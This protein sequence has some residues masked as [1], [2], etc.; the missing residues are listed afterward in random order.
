LGTAAVFFPTDLAPNSF[1]EWS[2]IVKLLLTQ[3]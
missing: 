1:P 3:I 2:F